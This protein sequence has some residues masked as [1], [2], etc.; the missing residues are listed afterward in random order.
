MIS[1]PSTP[2]SSASFLISASSAL[3]DVHVAAR[4]R[5]GVDAVGVEDDERPRQVRAGAALRHRQTDQADVAVHAG[6]LHDAVAGANLVADLLAELLLLGVG[7]LQLADVV[8]LLGDRQALADLSEL[9]SA[10]AFGYGG[11]R[12]G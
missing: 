4:R 10:F 5:E 1:C 9:S 7:H 12:P 8:R 3:R 2:A 6:I 11:T